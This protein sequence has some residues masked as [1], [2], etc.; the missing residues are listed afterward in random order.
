MLKNK[1][2]FSRTYK[3]QKTSYT[4]QAAYR[5]QRM[6]IN[7][8]HIYFKSPEVVERSLA[9]LKHLDSPLALSH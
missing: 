6:R 3:Q 4:I 1:V 2:Y 7:I 9:T 5:L 8:V